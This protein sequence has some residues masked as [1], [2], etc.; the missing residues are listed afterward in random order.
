MKFKLLICAVALCSATLS[1]QKDEWKDPK[2]NQVNRAPMHTNYFAYESEKAAKENVK[3]LSANFLSLNGPWRF[4]WVHDADARPTDFYKTTYDDKGWTTINV[5]GIWE[6]NGFGVPLYL[7][8]GYAWQNQFKNNPPDVPVE[9]NHVGSYRREITIPAGWS[10]KQIFAHFGSVTSNIYLWVNGQYV[11][12]SEDSKLEAEFNITSYL[13]PGKNLIAFQVFRWCDGSYLED[14]DFFRLS[15]VG[16]DCY[17]YTRN[18][19]Y[20]KDIRV[21]PDLDAQYKDGTLAIEVMLS[22]SGSV[23][24]DLLDK[25]GNQVATQT[26]KGNGK[27]TG[28]IQVANP[29]KWSA[30]APNLYTLIATLK[31]GDKTIEVIPL[32]TGFRKVEIKNAQLLVNGQPILIK[33]V[34]RHEMDPKTGYYISPERMVQDIKIMKEHNINAVRTSHYPNNNLWYELCDE[35]GLYVVAEANVEAHGMGYGEQTLA[36]NPLY[37]L[38]HLERNQRNV[39]R[40]YNHVSIITWSLG[41]ESGFGPNFEACYTW[42][43]NED[44]SRPVQYEQARTNDFTD[45]YCPM[46][47]PYAAS[48]RYAV[49]DDITKPLIQCEYAHAMG[50]SEGGFKEYWDMI[51]KHPKMQGGFIWDF[52]DQSLHWKNKDGIAIYGYGGDFNPY[53]ASDQNFCDNGLIGP[54]RIP[55]P[56]AHEVSYFYQ[57]IWAT[58]A[59][60][61]NGEINVFNE[62]FFRNLSA[63]YAE[64][65]LLADGEIVQTGTVNELNVAPQQT[66][67]IKL[68]YDLSDIP[69]GKEILLNVYFKLKKA[70]PLLPAGF[71]VA[72]S[73]I[74]IQPYKA[75]MPDIAYELTCKNC[76]AKP[77]AVKENDRHYLIVEGHDLRIEFNK[78]TGFLSRYDVNGNQFINEGGALTPNFWRAPTDNDLGANLQRRYS[79]WKNPVMQLTSLENK[80]ENNIV[81]VIAQYR[82]PE[83]S[84]LLS[85]TYLI[86]PNGDIQVT[87]KLTAKKDTVVSNMFRFGMQIQMPQVYDK[88]QYY[89]RGPIEN[90]SDRNASTFIGRFNQTVAEQFYPYIRPQETGTKTDIRWWRLFAINGDGLEFSGAAPFS[91]SALNYTIVSLDEG[92]K[93]HQTHSPEVKKADFTNFCID[94]KQ[95]GLGCVQSWGA[96]PLEPYMIPYGDY[97]FTFIMHPISNMFK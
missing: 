44:K 10:G 97:E 47:L 51:R 21:T 18:T 3:E 68:N 48:E 94:M 41:N 34:N 54:D 67:K 80:T 66:G 8:I 90:Y 92:D 76:H 87:Q 45:I 2:I 77:I 72:S 88:I 63:Y 65:I 55:N 12:Y 46:Y 13:K 25:K 52:V 9:N 49:R 59:N 6:V 24:L 78:A 82:M 75:S 20:I 32:K 70:E 15:G 16:R 60:L 86:N 85:L 29:E 37:A 31:D 35:Y 79:V 73:Q 95:M 40:G 64:W 57:S 33:G 30:E 56:H 11:G 83:L 4:N 58:P 14:Q 93:K 81:E 38:A 74:E 39:Q 84:A 23:Q 28:V 1:A 26:I 42:I 96:L 43:K 27:I 36:K 91:A 71:A 5:P 53:D 69:E 62:N 7:N 50:N 22:S 17:L 89:G 61:T 19:K